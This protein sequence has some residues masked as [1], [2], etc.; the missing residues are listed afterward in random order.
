MEHTQLE[1]HPEVF[2]FVR[3]VPRDSRSNRLNLPGR[4]PPWNNRRP[5]YFH[6][7]LTYPTPYI[8]LVLLLL[9]TASIMFFALVYFLVDRLDPS[10]QCGLAQ[11]TDDDV[12]VNI[13]F[14]TS[15]A[16]SLE[17]G[18]TVGYGLPGASD[19]FFND[20][21]GVQVAIYFQVGTDWVCQHCF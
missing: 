3:L 1:G 5:D 8:T 12:V 14:Y 4:R 10:V 16:F 19:A 9:W 13:A 20:C 18:T 21:P 2:P 11:A 17:T 7:F 6:I 15:V